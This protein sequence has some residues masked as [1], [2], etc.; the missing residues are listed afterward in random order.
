MD[1]TFEI[2]MDQPKDPVVVHKR[3]GGLDLLRLISAFLIVC[4]HICFDMGIPKEVGFNRVFEI[5]IG[6]WGIWCVDIFFISSALFAKD[7]RFKT[8]HFLREFLIGFLFVIASSVLLVVYNYHH[9]G[10]DLREAFR[11]MFLHG[12]IQTSL[13]TNYYWFLSVYLLVYLLFPFIKKALNKMNDKHLLAL[14]LCLLPIIIIS[15]FRESQSIMEDI[16][17][18]L[19][20]YI[21]VYYL[22]RKKFEPRWW[23]CLIVVL[24]VFAMVTCGR[25][26]AASIPPKQA[27]FINPIFF[28][29]SRHSLWML[30]G[31]Y[32]LVKLVQKWHLPG[33]ELLSL[34]SATTLEIYLFHLAPGLFSLVPHL[35]RD[36]MP[37]MLKV[38]LSGFASDPR[39][40]SAFATIAAFC[41][42]GGIIIG[43]ILNFLM[44]WFVGFLE[45]KQHRFF[46]SIDDYMNAPYFY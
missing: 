25:I 34:F 19:A 39:M 6:S 38:K 16:P 24:G 1:N 11:T 10:M 18:T 28:N 8:S 17:Y 35:V 7:S 14:C 29:N 13:W 40:P 33:N 21:W 46:S 42:V 45:K 26:Y 37:A 43:L 44:N 32:F 9:L 22:E 3:D 5:L 15:H 2:N 27:D 31:A 30:L 23:L 20:I 4:F 41:F 36:I 12:A